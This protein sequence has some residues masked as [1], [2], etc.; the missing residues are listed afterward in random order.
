MEDWRQIDSAESGIA[1]FSP[2]PECLLRGHFRKFGLVTEMSGLP[3][4]ADI[5][6]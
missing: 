4:E 1:L 6:R 2:A 5:V 3:S